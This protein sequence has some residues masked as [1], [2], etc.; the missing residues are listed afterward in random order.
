MS[1]KTLIQTIPVSGMTCG[2]CVQT[3]AKVLWAVPGVSEA[4]VDLEEKRAEVE[5]EP[6]SEVSVELLRDAVREAGY[7]VPEV[8]DGTK[9]GEASAKVVTIG[10][11]MPTEESTTVNGVAGEEEESAEDADSSEEW[12]LALGGMHCASCVVRVE[13]ALN[14]VPGV[15]DARVNLATERASL[16]LDPRTV[17]EEQL[18]EAVARAGYSARRA[19]TDLAGG[20][21]ALRRERAETVGIWRRRLI[22][23]VLLVLPLVVLGLG[24]MLLPGLFGHGAWIGWAMFALATPV[25]IYLGGPYLKGAFERLRQ[26]STN[27]DTLIALGSSTAYGYSL[28]HLLMGHTHQA[29][30]FMDSGIILTLITLG[31]YLEARSKG[32]AGSAIERLLDLAPKKAR[33]E[34]DGQEMEVPLSEVRRGE[35]VRVRPGEAVPVDGVVVEGDSSV[36][37]SMLTGESIPVE[38][39]VGDRVTGG[40]MNED[41]MLVVEAKRLGKESALEGIVRMV[42]EAQGSKAGVQR[43]ADRIASV[44]VPVVLGVALVTLLGW[45][46]VTADWGFGVLNAAA[47]LIIACPCALGLATPMAVAVATGRGAREGLLVREAS[48]FERM[49]KLRTVVL[50][51]TGTVTE[52]RPKVTDLWAVE[53]FEEGELARLAGAAEA[54]SEHPLARAVAERA[55]GLKASEF[56]AVRGQGVIATVEGKVVLVGSGRFLKESGVDLKGVEEVARK[57]EDEAK[58]VLLVAVDGKAAGAIAVADTIKP[59]AR[60]AVASLQLQGKEVV[61][62]T[63]DN[64]RTAKAIAHQA[65]ITT[66]FAE[67]RPDGKAAK[68]RELKKAGRVAMVG[69]G[70]N[71]APALAA[72]DVGIALGTGT[73]LAKAS[74]DVVIASGDLRAVPRALVL[75]RQ[76]LTAIRQNLF[77]AMIYNVVGIPAA[78]LGV[79][80]TYGPMIAAVAMSMSSVTVVGRSALLGWGAS[81]KS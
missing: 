2:H 78:A 62:L 42:K 25:Q 7:D 58:T 10:G 33:V 45:G 50:D 12:E 61:L 14:E 27:M 23:G 81:S 68:V 9:P 3:V 4:R 18:A 6:G 11:G 29:H 34:R 59:H 28:Y 20:A 16:I 79:F 64:P 51:K 53:G 44:F 74:A 22:V 48:A 73:D 60:E 36:D 35:R 52:G 40:T 72:A 46:L 17:H 55:E 49:D 54:G 67:V 69:D 38:K 70:L 39:A 30:F 37:E 65:G 43:L 5:F 80:G 75:G 57:W 15:R 26:G 19:Q 76:T 41:G 66:V 31:K 21:E 77:W 24:P 32:V 13:K 1:T 56:R 71:D 8:S 47:V 63:G